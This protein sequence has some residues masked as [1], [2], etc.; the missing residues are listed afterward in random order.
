MLPIVHRISGHHERTIRYPA[1]SIFKMLLSDIVGYSGYMFPWCLAEAWL[2]PAWSYEVPHFAL[3]GYWCTLGLLIGDFYYYTVHRW[4][5]L[6][7]SAFHF[8]HSK[9]HDPSA[10]M[11]ISSAGHVNFFGAIIEVNFPAIMHS[12]SAW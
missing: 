11:D 2:S 5:H 12:I 10:Q 7:K 3:L 4:F 1:N 8:F 6:N 9:H